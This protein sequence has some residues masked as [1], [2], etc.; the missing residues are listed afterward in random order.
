MPS[1]FIHD[2]NAFFRVNFARSSAVTSFKESPGT[3]M[4][5][6]NLPT[7]REPMRSFHPSN[8]AAGMIAVWDNL[9]SC[10]SFFSTGFRHQ[11]AGLGPDFLVRQG[12]INI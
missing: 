12:S 1:L 9:H 8:S 6:P 5:S 11:E 7:S 10:H 3:A 4:T 2:H